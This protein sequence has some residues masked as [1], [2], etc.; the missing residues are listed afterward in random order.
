MKR[1]LLVMLLS[2]SCPIKPLKPLKPLY[3][4]EMKAICVCDVQ[5]QNCYWIWVCV[6]PGALQVTK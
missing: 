6:K 1:L 4:P 2:A 3:C 5:G